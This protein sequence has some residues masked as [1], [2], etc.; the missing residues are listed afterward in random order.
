MDVRKCVCR[1]ARRGIVT[2]MDSCGSLPLSTAA[3]L[4][5]R[6]QF[7]C[8]QGFVTAVVEFKDPSSGHVCIKSSRTKVLG[9]ILVS[10]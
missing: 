3:R 7:S 4:H 2:K 6:L 1:E 9:S 8:C 5:A 10:S